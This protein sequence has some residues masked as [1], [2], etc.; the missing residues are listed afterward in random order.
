MKVLSPTAGFTAWG[1]DKGT[2]NSQGIWPWSPVRFDYKTFTGLGE[3]ETPVLE[4]TNKTLHAPRLRGKEQWLLHRRLNQN[5]LL[6]LEGLLWRRESSGAHYRDG[7]LVW[8]GPPWYT[9]S[10]CVYD[11]LS[12]VSNSLWAHGLGSARL[13]CP[14]NSPGKNTGVCS[15]ACL[16]GIF[17]TWSFCFTGIF[18]T[19]W[20]TNTLRDHH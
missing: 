9:R 3:T 7:A 15:H 6:V 2:R 12:V 13:L 20:A 19:I 8:E 11:S 18:F 16:Q 5:D 10:W 1:S 4:S 17:P 14:R